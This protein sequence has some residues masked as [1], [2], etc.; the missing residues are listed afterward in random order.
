MMSPDH[1]H[2]AFLLDLYGAAARDESQPERSPEESAALIRSL[3]TR[4][5]PDWVIHTGGQRHASI[6]DVQH[7]MTVSARR[8]ELTGDTFEVAVDWALADDTWGAIHSHVTAHRD[9]RTL[10]VES[11][12]MWR[13]AADGTPV[14][15]WEL[16]S[17]P[18]AWDAFW[19]D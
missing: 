6:G 11:V 10:D 14:E 13:F 9:G 12:G 3:T 19:D 18:E 2:A 17:D 15:H 4:F 1:P 5:S 7:G 8:R 16:I